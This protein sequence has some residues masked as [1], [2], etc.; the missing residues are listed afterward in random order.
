MCLPAS[1]VSKSWFG[2]ASCTKRTTAPMARC[3]QHSLPDEWIFVEAVRLCLPGIEFHG[4]LSCR[5]AASHLNDFVREFLPAEGDLTTV[6]AGPAS[7]RRKV[8]TL[9][10]FTRKTKS[11][12]L[13]RALEKPLEG[14]TDLGT[15]S[16]LSN[17]LTYRYPEMPRKTGWI[18]D[19]RPSG[20]S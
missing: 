2:K 15:V 18:L 6:T 11:R 10:Y 12:A 14:G 16:G 13:V 17:D 5:D 3:R 20:N 9:P 7:N 1:C 4:P 19:Q 8:L